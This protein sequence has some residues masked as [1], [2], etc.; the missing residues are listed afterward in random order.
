MRIVLFA[1]TDWYLYNFRLSTALQ[2]KSMDIDVVMVSPPGEFCGRFA[3]HGIRWVPLEMDRASLNPLQEAGTLRRL[4]ALLKAEKPDL[5]H[6]F[7]LKCAVYGALAARAAG[8][9]AVVNAVTGLG[10]VFSSDRPKARMLR[11]VVS[12]LM[13]STLGFGHS[14]VILQNGDDAAAFE[15][16]KLA[17][18]E[19]IRLIRSSGVNI[20]RFQSPLRN[21]SPRRPLRVLLAARLVWEKGIGEFAEAA[22]LLRQQGRD[23]E[24][25]LAGLPDPGNPRSVS[26]QQA[27][28]WQAQGVLQWLGH[29]D[30]M[31]ALLGG[32]DVMALPSYYREGVPKSLIEAAA[33][34][35]ALV[36]TNL[37]G[38]KEVVTVD[39]EDGLYVEPRD[40][41]SL[42]AAL[43]KLDDDR[44]LLLRLGQRAREQALQHFDERVVVRRTCEVYAELLRLPLQDA[45]AVTT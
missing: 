6:S 13:R 27:S 41:R 38:C 40:A 32:V 17:P 19:N 4:I 31:P 21:A 15:N 2:L 25:L 42:S 44:E 14:R 16:L 20:E 3:Q 18:K 33:C 35:V 28:E 30:D 7:T 10:Y 11:P 39:G 22:A 1:N 37:P 12:L 43:A 24:F 45:V 23:I 36:T 5:L 9:P 34:G 8:V 29:V 26:H